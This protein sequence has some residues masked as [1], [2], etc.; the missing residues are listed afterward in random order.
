M[1]SN[2]RIASLAMAA[3][4]D[5]Y[6]Q[7]GVVA[8]TSECVPKVATVE[9]DNT[10][11]TIY[12]NEDRRIMS[13]RGTDDPEDWM[14]NL[15]MAPER[16]HKGRIYESMRPF[17]P[18]VE[19]KVHGGFYKAYKRLQPA[20]RDL[21]DEYHEDGLRWIV[22]GHSLG[23]ALANIACMSMRWER[24]PD[25]VTFGSPR[26]GNQHA[27]WICSQKTRIMLRFTNNNDIVPM[28]PAPVGPWKHS[29]PPIRLHGENH[30][31]VSS[32]LVFDYRVGLGRY[33]D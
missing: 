12:A 14:E 8:A 1:I 16:T 13:F 32:H 11:L 2:R 24:Q 6:Y 28:L 5:S 10:L 26:W 21:V 18:S 31:L 23:G 7:Y 27:C 22:T 9:V 29:S 3:C 19:P 25:L 15:L 17:V 33:N 4:V 20:L 30:G